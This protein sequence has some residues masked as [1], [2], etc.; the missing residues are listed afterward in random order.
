[1]NKFKNIK[2]LVSAFMML[3]LLVTGCIFPVSA[4]ESADLVD[5]A[6][7]ISN[8]KISLAVDESKG[9]ITLTE[10]STGNKFYSTP[11]E[12][13]EEGKTDALSRSRASSQLLIDVVDDKGAA[14]TL[15]SNVANIRL[16]S[17]N[18]S[19]TVKYSFPAEEIDLS[20]VYTLEGNSF[21]ATIPL[22]SIKENGIFSI[23]KISI[24]PY[25]NAA[26]REEKGYIL[27]PD[28]SGALI[29]FNN[30]K[31]TTLYTQK[32][33]GTDPITNRKTMTVNTQSV[34][35]P[36]IGIHKEATEGVNSSNIL[37]YVEDGAA[38]AMINATS[39]TAANAYNY[40]Y[41]SFVYRS[42]AF[43]TMLENTQFPVSATMLAN[44]TAAGESFSV[45][46]NIL[47]SNGDYNDMAA[48]TR[49][50]L[51]ADGLKA[52]KISDKVYIETFMSVKKTK[53][54][55]GIPYKA[56]ENLTTF[57]ECI[58]FVSKLNGN[59]VMILNG[60]DNDGAVGGVIDTKFAVN[61]KL[62]GIKDYKAFVKAAKE[63]NSEVFP[64]CEFVLF[65]KSKWG[66]TTYWH[67]A[68]SVDVKPVNKLY[69][70][71]GNYEENK[72]YPKLRYLIPTKLLKAGNSY[73]KSLNK[74]GITAAAP[75]TIGNSPYSSRDGKGCDI[76]SVANNYTE[77]LGN[78][79]KQ[80]ISI[81]LQSPAAYALN[82]T[83]Y[84]YGMP[85][86]S[87][88][89]TCFDLDIPFVQ[90]VLNGLK[91]YS[92]VS[93]NLTN[94]IP[95]MKLLMLESASAPTYT[96]IGK[97]YKD[98]KDTPL[99]ILYGADLSALEENIL[100]EVNAYRDFYAK[101][102]GKIA[103]HTTVSKDLRIVEFENGSKI[104]INYDDNAVE[105]DGITIDAVSYKLVEGGV[106]NE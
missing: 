79:K 59:A 90:L 12:L 70:L 9:G 26:D 80:G 6:V 31:G 58:D 30:G 106:S 10:L 76:V 52:D 98:V 72:D 29:N 68:R 47:A 18:K 36:I 102:E 83:D 41:M 57:D 66:Y 8:D 53:H 85:L 55:L 7:V 63:L 38:A 19:I 61:S 40:G 100:K 93:I 65:D 34:L 87:S 81:A 95:E 48:K 60:L 4:V 11:L 28:G 39:A 45:S 96:V 13:N 1:M 22:D 88:N 103:K 20:L 97:E 77:I 32:V 105:Y 91:N 82:F 35:L 2:L 84:A 51:V 15:T 16:S 86:R 27:V 99:D 14:S 71:Y 75:L 104:I 64:V 62:G 101:T 42:S 50:K 73:I 3:S 78:M 21:V 43:I 92:T 5:G 46:Y 94:N 56:N 69:Y 23:V 33:Y 54:F 67:N 44:N 74:N 17:N 37:L 24:L 49:E 25:F 89:F